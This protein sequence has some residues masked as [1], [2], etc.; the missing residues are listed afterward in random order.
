M[1]WKLKLLWVVP[2]LLTLSAGA[3]NG[4]R[5]KSPPD[6][7]ACARTFFKEYADSSHSAYPISLFITSKKQLLV[8]DRERIDPYVA[9]EET[10]LTLLDT[11]GNTIAS[12]FFNG[13][14]RLFISKVVALAN[15]NYAAAGNVYF[16]P[17]SSGLFVLEFGPGLNILWEK[18][19]HFAAPYAGVLDMVES[20]EGDL[21]LYLRDQPATMTENRQLLKLDASGNPAWFREYSA[22]AN[23]FQGETEIDGK[24]A[25]LG[26]F[27]YLKYN[28]ES[29]L[30]P[31]ILKIRKDDG[32][33]VWGREYRLDS[34]MGPSSIALFSFF[35]DEASLYLN[36]RSN[37]TDVLLKI[38]SATGKCLRDVA[39]SPNAN[40]LYLDKMIYAGNG[41]II[42]SAGAGNGDILGIVEM[43]TGFRVLRK[44]LL[45]VSSTGALM[46]VA[47]LSDS[48]TYTL[49]LFYNSN[50]YLG[51][52]SLAK[53]NFKSSFASCQVTNPSL[54]FQPLNTLVVTVINTSKGLPLPEAVP[55]SI[56][57]VPG[58]LAYS[59][60][61][62]GNQPLCNSI[63]ISGPAA[64]CD[65][66]TY[67]Y[68]ALR[69]PGCE[70]HVNWIMNAS[71]DSVE[72]VN[73]TD[74]SA[75]LHIK[76]QGR[77]HLQ[78][79]IFGSCAWISDSM[80]IQAAITSHAT[81]SLGPDTT[82]CDGNQIILN[83]GDGF[84][85]YKWQDGSTDSVFTVAQPGTYYVTVKAG[86]S[87]TYTDSIH[88]SLHSPIPFDLGA[89]T[90]VCMGDSLTIKAP[91][92][93]TGYQWTPG[94]DTTNTFTAIPSVNTWYSVRAHANAGCTVGD[95]IFVAVKDAP[96][97][98]LGND[99]SFC[100]GNSINLDAGQGWNTYRWNTGDSGEAITATQAR[101]YKVTAFL[102]G[103]RGSD[104]L[105][106]LNVFPHPSFSLG[107]DTTLCEGQS[108][109]F[110]FT[111]SGAAY[112]WNTG[113][114]TGSQKVN[115]PGKYWLQVI[116]NGCSASDTL[117]VNYQPA[118]I[119]ML[120]N[121]TT[122]CEGTSLNLSAYYSNATYLWQDGSTAPQFTVSSAG[123]YY[124]IAA[125]GN[126]R[127]YD[128]INIHTSPLPRFTLGE[129]QYLCTG[130]SITL[131]PV[132][133]TNVNYL[134]QD[135]STAPTYTVTKEGT[136]S[137]TATNNCGS[138]T[139]SVT[140]TIG[141]C[142]LIMPTAFTP[143][144]DGLNDIFRVKYA[145]PVQTFVLRV[146]NRFG[147]K[148]F[149]SNDIHKG[150]NGTFKG[151]NAQQG[152]YVWTISLL[153][154]EGKAQSSK[155]VVVLLR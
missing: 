9:D 94:N 93:F 15:G 42:A 80:E 5:T 26:D 52:I 2:L 127:S 95:S 103:C 85:A 88:V 107:A 76:K 71:P 68:S 148:V 50:P 60:Y 113:N 46:D 117:A 7:A 31:H 36:G 112:F 124:A 23:I 115:Q 96:V 140:I 58:T 3:Q 118:P 27:I 108:L 100:E 122:I 98:N 28:E 135:R 37:G 4:L 81:L 137:L 1:K 119:V 125:I 91:A 136:Y 59:R 146:Y 8:V 133:N 106:I 121:D 79:K 104:S 22:G 44:Q 114:T 11:S 99:T 49:G 66:G 141:L 47:A 38:D 6:S 69:N 43:D 110:N 18:A 14:K 41:R 70:A 12:K 142:G 102:N 82:I 120:G 64:L 67:H 78:A 13:S 63:T 130:Q 92:N 131:G 65:S 72:L 24:L 21:Y 35:T 75:D 89:D 97:I 39:H 10:S 134:W 155:G 101:L 77:Y 129:D 143:N 33:L 83:A 109:T 105:T 45:Q 74:T 116:Q 20:S 123:T 132:I 84:S 138:F 61:Y 145:F 62:C 30:I 54:A 19:L 153:T 34:I 57:P 139:D 86:C 144:S 29:Y 51:T 48:V 32:S 16:S 90:S 55:F 149:E 56:N 53:F 40:G 128:T 152:A 126:C 25:T 151:E 147:E 73:A 150:W 17:D 87:N 154:A 111:M